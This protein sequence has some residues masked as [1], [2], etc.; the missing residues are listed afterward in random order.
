[1]GG[2]DEGMEKVVTEEGLRQKWKRW[3][4]EEWKVKET[5]MGR[6]AKWSLKGGQPRRV[7]EMRE[8]SRNREARCPGLYTRRG[9]W[10]EVGDVGGY[11]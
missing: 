10:E 6:V 2:E 1:L 11:G 4:A 8:V 9:H 5:G 7:P 3:K